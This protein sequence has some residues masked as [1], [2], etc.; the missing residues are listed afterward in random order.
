MND[1]LLTDGKSEP[2]FF[3]IHVH[4]DL[5]IYPPS[6]IVD[7]NIP[8]AMILDLILEILIFQFEVINNKMKRH[9]LKA[10]SMNSLILLTL[11]LAGIQFTWTVELA[12]G[13]PYLLSLGLSKSLTC[14]LFHH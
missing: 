3:I 10:C 9:D 14:M 13:T 5:L 1:A 7:I 12:Y 6:S 4:V 11:A 8:K 2:Y